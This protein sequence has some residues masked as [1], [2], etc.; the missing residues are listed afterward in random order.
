MGGV[1][2]KEIEDILDGLK[3]SPRV[4]AGLVKAIPEGR[5]EI[6]RGEGFWTIA[7]QVSHLAEVQPMM[8]GRFQR[9]LE[10][11]HPEFV[12]FIPSGGDDG[13]KTQ[14]RL[15]MAVA[16]AQF[17]DYREKQ[18]E[19]LEGLDADAWQKTGTHPEYELYSLSILARHVLMHD[20]WHMYRIEEL[21]LTR[22]AYLKKIE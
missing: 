9:F 8:L 14:S 6:R 21:W 3:R 12:P 22:D 16:L 10:E 17:E 4:L 13:P 7:E 18:L 1:I 15:E 11:N 19:L 5:S 2:M 20:Y